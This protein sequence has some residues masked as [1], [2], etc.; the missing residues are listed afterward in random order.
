MPARAVRGGADAAAPHAL[1]GLGDR[2]VSVPTPEGFVEAASRNGAVRRFFEAAEA[3]AFDFLG[4]YLPARVLEQFERG[5]HVPGL[6]FY[7]RGAVAGGLREV[8]Y[9]Q[10]DFSKLVAALSE[11][12]RKAIDLNGP[13]IRAL[14]KQQNRKL[15]DLLRGR[16]RTELSQSVGLGEIERTAD[17][18]GRLLLTKAAFERDGTRTEKLL[19]SGDCAVRVRGRLVW[20]FTYKV[21]NSEKDAEDLRAFTKQWLAE[22]VRANP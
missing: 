20:V 10:E 8:A 18:H 4:A 1:F 17:S 22:I 7:G 13:E 19:L 9:S 15:S 5:E 21:F 12:D 14:L 2:E 11:D 6:G 16:L 3:P